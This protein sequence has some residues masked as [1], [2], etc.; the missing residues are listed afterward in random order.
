L[1]CRTCKLPL[2]AKTSR[3]GHDECYVCRRNRSQRERRKDS[4]QSFPEAKV[5]RIVGDVLARF[6]IPHERQ[7]TV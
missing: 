4:K 6:Y 5:G 2:N 7:E 3:Y 1:T